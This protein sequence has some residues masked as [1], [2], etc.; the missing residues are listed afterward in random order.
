MTEETLVRIMNETALIPNMSMGKR[1]MI[2]EAVEGSRLA[3]SGHFH[4]NY[5]SP[6]FGGPFKEV[7]KSLIDRLEREGKLVRAYPDRP[8][9]NGWVLP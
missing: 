5:G 7:P 4:F 3:P 9:L 2:Y 1:R 8:E 6:E